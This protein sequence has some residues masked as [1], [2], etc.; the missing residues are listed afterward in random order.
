MFEHGAGGAN[1]VCRDLG[2]NQQKCT[3][4]RL[5]IDHTPRHRR[6]VAEIKIFRHPHVLHG[7]ENFPL[8]YQSGDHEVLKWRN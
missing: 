7:R 8:T 4:S 3:L 2:T 6:S 5:T 1:G